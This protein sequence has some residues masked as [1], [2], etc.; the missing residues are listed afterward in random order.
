MQRFRGGLDAVL[1]CEIEL[2]HFYYYCQLLWGWL[3][4]YWLP[5]SEF[6]PDDRPVYECYL[7][8]PRSGERN[9]YLM[10]FC[11]PVLQPGE[12]LNLIY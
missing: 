2:P 1:R 4:N 6:E 10:E 3:Y 5:N 12:R 7:A 11:V 9:S 8:S